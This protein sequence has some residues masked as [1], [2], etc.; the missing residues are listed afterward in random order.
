[1]RN[2]YIK[3]GPVYSRLADEEDVQGLDL[4]KLPEQWRKDKLR[5]HQART[6]QAY[7]DSTIN[8]IFDTALTGDGKS[9]AGQFPMLVE[10]Q[11]AM[12]LYPTNELIRDQ[13]KQVKRYLD[14][15][16][17]SH[18]YQMLYSEKISEEIEEFG[19]RS[20]SAVIRNWLKNRD[21]ILSNP[22]LFHLLI[23][24]KYHELLQDSASSST[25]KICFSIGNT[26]HS[27]QK[28]SHQ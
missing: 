6:W 5:Y 28:H 12:F 15:F 11:R 4:T 13:E 24:R 27:F 9:L 20:R 22:D 7:K 2:L 21:C 19:G 16:A 26:K 3:L 23:G 18:A 1:M 14:E 8:V 10:N 25:N 17:Q